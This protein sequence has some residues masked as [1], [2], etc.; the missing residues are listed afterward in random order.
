MS[1]IQSLHLLQSFLSDIHKMFA[2]G[3]RQLPLISMTY[4]SFQKIRIKLVQLLLM[5]HKHRHDLESAEVCAALLTARNLTRV[6][7]ETDS[8]WFWLGNEENL[9]ECKRKLVLLTL[10]KSVLSTTEGAS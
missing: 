1:V 5:E 7:K 8:L 10:M 6:E 2:L 3:P 9:R 4:G